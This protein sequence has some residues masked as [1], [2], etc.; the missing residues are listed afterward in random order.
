MKINAKMH[1]GLKTMIELAM[2][3][4]ETGMLQK[5]VAV[6]QDMPNKFLDSVIHSLKVAGLIVNVGGRKSGYKLARPSAEI[7]V[8][9]VYRAFEPELRINF[10]LA[11]YE[12][13]PRT[14]SCASRIFLCELNEK[15]RE[16]MKTS[17]IG[18]LATRELSFCISTP[19]QS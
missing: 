19:A 1:Y 8:Y 17:T 2:N 10:C 13:C 3:A 6:N 14:Q 5:E 9:D 4:G 16:Y 18:A 15:M 12:S 7:S 11:D